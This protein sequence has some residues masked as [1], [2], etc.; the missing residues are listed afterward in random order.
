[1]S[2][3][4]S[5]QQGIAAI[6]AQRYDEG[7]RLLR[8]ALEDNTL[9]GS[10]RATAMMW[11][12]EISNDSQEKIRYYTEALSIDPANELAQQRMAELL[13]PPANRQVPAAAPTSPDNPLVRPQP[14]A[15][16]FQ[17][18]GVTLTPAIGA[19]T[20]PI[21]PPVYQKPVTGT[22]TM[23][24]VPQNLFTPVAAQQNATAA[25]QIVGISGG[26]NGPGS[27][28]FISKD[29][30]IATTRFVIGGL[31]SV[32]VETETRRQMPGQVV[33]SFPDL[34]IAFVYINQPIT[35]L[36]PV[37]PFPSIPDNAPITALTHG[38]KMVAGRKRETGRAI[39]PHLF[40]TDIVQVPD[41]GGCPIFD[42]RYYLVGM[43]TRN[44][45]SSSSYVYGIHIS[46]I[47]RALDL[48]YSE[49]RA[50]NQR[51][52]CHSCGF[53]SHAAGSGG[54]YC[55]NCG[56]TMPHAANVQRF[57][58][59]QL[60]MFYAENNPTACPHCYA[61]AGFYNGLCLR[62]GRGEKAAGR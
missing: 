28:F 33:R 11:L 35:D 42:E 13:R 2:A 40:P 30:L 55:E 46:A 61:R 7:R 47:R 4:R 37:S 53:V 21:Q 10:L 58:T 16:V 49:M 57:P 5:F 38:G 17:P 24:S 54:H 12:A 45:S 56:S 31:E 29:G 51:M 8:I 41:A 15:P 20:V 26:S 32:T 36:L 39:A 1:M 50:T 34:D 27:G 23:P 3:I 48:F 52:Y 25:Y 62:C 60:T 6:E 44:I 14:P 18:P 9:S 19:E 22:L 43:L 59:P